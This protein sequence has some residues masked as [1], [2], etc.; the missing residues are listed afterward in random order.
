MAGLV[1]AIH[2]FGYQDK[3]DVDVRHKA[4]HDDLTKM[5]IHFLPI[6][7]V[8]KAAASSQIGLKSNGSPS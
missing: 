5:S 3:T 6:R 8:F 2:V 4:G 7:A 1:P